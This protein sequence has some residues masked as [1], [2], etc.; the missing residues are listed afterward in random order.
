MKYLV[1]KSVVD[2]VGR[3]WM[4]Q[5]VCSLRITMSQYDLDNARDD[6]GKITRDS[7]E[8]WL[9][10]HTGDFSQI[11]DWQASIEDGSE[12]LEFPFSTEDGESQYLNTISE[13]LE[14]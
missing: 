14:A 13:P 4:P 1:R 5:A 11:I 6:D 2:V 12:T 10:T 9:M 8:L 3:I 7:L